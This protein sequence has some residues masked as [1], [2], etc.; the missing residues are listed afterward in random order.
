MQD[1]NYV[2]A[3]CMELTIEMSCCKYPEFSEIEK[4]WNDNKDA[5]V[6]LLGQVDMGECLRPIEQTHQ[7]ATQ[8]RA[9]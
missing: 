4:F 6:A 2:F 8:T 9:D 1:F 5:L 7:T 3:G